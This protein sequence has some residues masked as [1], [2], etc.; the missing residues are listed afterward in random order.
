M[1]VPNVP[2]P[3]PLIG[4]QQDLVNNFTSFDTEI[5]TVRDSKRQEYT[6]I[7]ARINVAPNYSYPTT[8]TDVSVTTATGMA[9]EIPAGTLKTSAGYFTGRSIE[10]RL[11]LGINFKLP[12]SAC[13]VR[14]RRADAPNTEIWR[15]HVDARKAGNFP[16]GLNSCLE[17]EG[18]LRPTTDGDVDGLPDTQAHANWKLV[19][20]TG[21]SESEPNRYGGA[22]YETYP[23]E[24]DNT[25]AIPL[26]I[27]I[28][29]DALTDLQRVRYHHK[30]F[31]IPCAGGDMIKTRRT[32]AGS[33]PSSTATN[34][35]A[36]DCDIRR[37]NIGDVGSDGTRLLAISPSSGLISFSNDGY[38]W[39]GS[40]SGQSQALYGVEFVPDFGTD[41]MWVLVGANGVVLTSP[42][43]RKWTARTTGTTSVVRNIRYGS[44]VG[45]I[46]PILGTG[47]YLQSSDGVT[48]NLT[49]IS[50]RTE[51]YR[52]VAINGSTF[53]LCGS[54]GR[55]SYWNGSGWNHPQITG[56][57]TLREAVYEPIS[58]K[59]SVYGDTGTIAYATDPA[60]TWTIVT[61]TGLTGTI[62][63]AAA[64]ADGRILICTST[65]MIYYSIDGGTTWIKMEMTGNQAGAFYGDYGRLLMGV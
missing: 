21:S 46:A 26:K 55:I 6:R 56:S 9:F 49:Q 45:A 61:A 2:A 33:P 43:G 60:G 3:Q 48:W 22:G 19:G 1:P 30:R 36:S 7:V 25:S 58:G 28:Q 13:T 38:N 44:S 37:N 4:V 24:M 62:Q 10:I 18:W 34:L 47:Q 59:W 57:P 35:Y 40:D 5:A 54:S 23:G 12:T 29:W 17:M 16:S 14:V 31:W 52:G 65:G 50:G 8:E 32:D 51:Q 64:G 41:G 11:G 42:S 63:G 27:T 15:W 39:L 20:Y 53:L